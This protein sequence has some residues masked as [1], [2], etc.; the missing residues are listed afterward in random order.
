[1]VDPGHPLDDL[2][3]QLS[4]GDAGAVQRLFL[5]SEP[6]LRM[7]VRRHLTAD[8]RVRF[9]SLDI[10]QSI[11]ADL[12]P[13]FQIGRW[14]FGS[15]QQLQA[16]LVRVTRNRLIDRVRQQQTSLRREQRIA[17]D[18]QEHPTTPDLACRQLEAEEMWQRLL[19][20]CPERHRSLLEL[21]RQGLSLSEVAQRTGLHEGSVRRILA[22]LAARLAGSNP[23]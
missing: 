14:R 2:L 3:A 19:A 23:R 16:F 22:E 9:D 8:L 10:V 11:W 15:P 1:M 20:L 12:L 18:L 4:S 5:A 21:K 7:V 13:D 6:Y 17:V